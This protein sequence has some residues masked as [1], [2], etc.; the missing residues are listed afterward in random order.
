[1]CIRKR[2]SLLVFLAI[3]VAAGLFSRSGHG[4]SLPW[5][6]RQYAGDTLWAVAL[7]L[8]IAFLKPSARPG[9]IMYLSFMIA[10]A[11]EFSQ[12]YQADWINSLRSAGPMGYLLGYGFLWSDIL[13]YSS[14]ILFCFIGDSIHVSRRR[15]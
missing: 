13:C 9:E 11:V 10:L 8:F 15:F 2:S 3:T 6:I 7:Y 5:L 14:G 1:M 12:L 4:G